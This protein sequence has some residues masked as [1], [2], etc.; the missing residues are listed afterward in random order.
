M[1]IEERVAFSGLVAVC[2]WEGAV[3]GVPR[4]VP[5]TFSVVEAA[6][7][8]CCHSP[9]SPGSSGLGW[10]GLEN[11]CKMKAHTFPT[12]VNYWRLLLVPVCSCCSVF[13]FGAEDRLDWC[14]ALTSQLFQWGH[15]LHM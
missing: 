4:A 10:A 15:C 6:V 5:R 9:G 1:L 2:W 11:S 14:P 8:C 3:D 12:E 13:E 7:G